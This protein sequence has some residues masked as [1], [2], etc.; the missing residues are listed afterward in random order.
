MNFEIGQAIKIQVLDRTADK[1]ICGTFLDEVPGDKAMVEL[2]GKKEIWD[3]CRIKKH[4]KLDRNPD[5]SCPKLDDFV[6]K[7]WDNL[8]KVVTMGVTKILTKAPKLEIDEEEK[9]ISVDN[10]WIS[11]SAGT[12]ETV[13]IVGFVE[14]PTWYIS[15]AVPTGGSYWE[16][17]DV[18]TI[19]IGDSPNVIGAA[20]L[21]V[22]TIWKESNKGFWDAVDDHLWGGDP[23]FELAR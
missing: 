18:D 16:P 21:F 11:I 4:M 10:G 1:W 2:R 6:A 3:V 12:R 7:H 22:T 9:I 8:K 5:G 23:N 14:Q 13:S 20:E 17:P 15:I 19:E